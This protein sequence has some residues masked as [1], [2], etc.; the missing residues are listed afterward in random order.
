MIII[1]QV[2]LTDDM[3]GRLKCIRIVVEIKQNLT[4]L[5]IRNQLWVD[6]TGAIYFDP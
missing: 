6:T 3:V 1:F 5:Y 4:E 2:F